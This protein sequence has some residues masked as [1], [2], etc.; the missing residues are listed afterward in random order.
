MK[1]ISE[2]VTEA[3]NIMN[4]KTLQPWQQAVRTASSRYHHVATDASLRWAQ[5]RLHAEAQIRASKDLKQA[6][7]ESISQ[8]VLQAGSMGLTLN[9]AKRQCYLIPR[10][11]SK[12]NPNAPIIAYASPSYIGL[13]HVAVSGGVAKAVRA[14]EVYRAD[15]FHPGGPF[16]KPYHRP[17]TVPAERTYEKCIGVYALALL[18][19][20]VWQYEY[21][22]AD[23]VGRIRAMSEFPNGTMWHPEKLWTEGWKKAVVRRLCKLLPEAGDGRLALATSILDEHEGIVLDNE[24][25]QPEPEPVIT[26]EQAQHLQAIL[27]EI[28]LN[29]QR[30][31]SAYGIERLEDLPAS[32]WEECLARLEQAKRVAS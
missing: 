1:H 21:M 13:V 5:E 16:D 22:D 20:N 14:I 25:P 3:L 30:V 10:K 27:A 7:P 15:D 9:P 26:P 24:V 2:H 28:R 29:P 6:L 23:T 18:G 31:L 32:R 17:T 8:A 19:D 4:D 12:K 11:A